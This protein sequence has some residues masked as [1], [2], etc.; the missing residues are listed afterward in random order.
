MIV[1]A[2]DIT[3]KDR[4]VLTIQG[5]PGMGKT[6]LALS[7][8]NPLIFDCDGKLKK[9]EIEHKANAGIVR[10]KSVEEILTDLK[11]E[12]IKAYDTIIFDTA[13]TLIDYIISYV[14]K[15]NPKNAQKDGIT[16]T[17]KAWGPIK[18][19]FIKII[20]YCRITLQKD[21]IIVCH[22]KEDRKGDE[23]KYYMDVAGTAS[24]LF[25]AQKSDLMG[26]MEIIGNKR[27]IGFSP[28][29]FYEAK[30]AF[31]IKGVIEIPELT[32]G[33][34][35]LF[36]TYLFNRIDDYIAGTAE[37]VN[38]MKHEYEEV[39]KNVK[40]IINNIKDVKT[41]N[42]ARELFKDMEFPYN[43]RQEA[44][45]LLKQQVLAVGLEWSYEKQGFVV[46]K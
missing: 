37:K 23:Y 27:T 19:T 25:I 32:P 1:K 35:N 29:E 24:R 42:K 3:E 26:M 30:S 11:S 28:T 10:V 46:K 4:T 5:L 2:S 39:M 6:T 17:L 12:E 7:A 13:G 36:V 22:A 45:T 20:D 14:I 44:Q 34:S 40:K 21:V 38:E 18:Q 31:G 15:N 9:V 43:S 41:A 33:V 8:P 16:P